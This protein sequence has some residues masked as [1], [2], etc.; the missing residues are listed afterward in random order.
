MVIFIHFFISI[1]GLFFFL[2][3]IFLTE[4]ILICG[5]SVFFFGYDD[6][7]EIFNFKGLQ[8]IFKNVRW[9]GVLGSKEYRGIWEWENWLLG[10]NS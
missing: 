3:L 5:L 10:P 1:C 6:Y 2:G 9:S 8:F 4:K 7:G